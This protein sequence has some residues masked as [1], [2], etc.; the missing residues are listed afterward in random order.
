VPTL[1]K[2]ATSPIRSAPPRL[3][4]IRRFCL[5]L[6]EARD[7]QLHTRVADDLPIVLKHL[8]QAILRMDTVIHPGGCAVWDDVD[9]HAGVED[10][11]GGCS[12]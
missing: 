8:P 3:L 4:P 10:R 1:S 9:L 7:T 11:D 5:K 2:L 12:A 6:A